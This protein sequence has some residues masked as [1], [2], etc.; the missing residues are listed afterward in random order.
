MSDLGIMSDLGYI[1]EYGFEQ[2]YGSAIDFSWR[3]FYFVLEFDREAIW[4]RLCFSLEFSLCSIQSSWVFG[5]W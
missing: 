1:N 4:P 3:A 2:R 5:M